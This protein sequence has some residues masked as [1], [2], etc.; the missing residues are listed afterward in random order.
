MEERDSE[1]DTERKKKNTHTSSSSDFSST[2][3]INEETNYMFVPRMLM[4]LHVVIGGDTI[5]D[6]R[7][8]VRAC[9]RKNL[10]DC[11]RL[12]H[13]KEYSKIPS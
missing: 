4:R 2:E 13:R 7:C 12:R 6:G 9:V 1:R 5:A 10:F 11:V 8:F 3:F